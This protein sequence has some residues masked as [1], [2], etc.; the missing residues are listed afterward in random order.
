ME[1]VQGM[2]NAV[3]NL[4]DVAGNVATYGAWAVAAVG[5]TYALIKTACWFQRVRL[6][7]N[8]W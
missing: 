3:H 8:D 4:V 5:V 2:I 7:K 6:L 1:Q